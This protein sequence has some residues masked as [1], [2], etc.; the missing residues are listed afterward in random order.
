VYFAW[1]GKT[2]YFSFATDILVTNEFEGLQF[3]MGAS[4]RLK[5]N[6]TTLIPDAMKTGLGLYGNLGVL[7]AITIGCRALSWLLLEMA[8]V[9]K[10][11]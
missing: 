4:S 1:I 2:S 11:L 10:F 6:A 8:A 9:F 5:V 7:A 3:S